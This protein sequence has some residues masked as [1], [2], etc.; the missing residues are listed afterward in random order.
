[1]AKVLS[2][3]VD[4]NKRQCPH[5]L[6]AQKRQILA[7]VEKALMQNNREFLQKT[8]GLLDNITAIVEQAN[9]E[10]QRQRDDVLE[11]VTGIIEKGNRECLQQK[12]DILENVTAIVQ[13]L[14]ASFESKLKTKEIQKKPR[15]CVEVQSMDPR[16]VVT[17]DNGMTVV[18]DT[19][20]DNG[21]WVVFQRRASANVD[22]FRGWLGYRDG[23]G[24]L[25][26]NFW[27]GL[28]KVH[29]LTKMERHELRIDFSFQG[30]DYHAKYD[31]FSLSGESENYKI[32]ISGFSGNMEDN[33]DYHNGHEF[34]TKDRDNDKSS[35]NCASTYHG[36]WWY[37]SCHRVNLNGDWGST[38]SSMGLNWKAVTTYSKS[39]TFSEMKIRPFVQ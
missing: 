19:K 14:E 16:L 24:D 35:S 1:M 27:L 33:M 9:K 5:Q 34:T 38:E 7:R 22:F 29:Q 8:E 39:V 30:T 21:G 17:L 10:L 12:D 3:V 6:L 2:D 4:E 13:A 25:H 37:N 31:N 32:H 20:T 23:F 28:E 36:A 18:C 11:D 26:S 15:T